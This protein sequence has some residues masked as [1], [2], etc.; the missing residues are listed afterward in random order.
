MSSDQSGEPPLLQEEADPGPETG[1]KDEALLGSEGGSGGMV[2]EAFISKLARFAKRPQARR[3]AHYAPLFVI[4]EIHWT[5]IEINRKQNALKS[6]LFKQTTK[7]S[8]HMHNEQP[9]HGTCVIH[10][11]VGKRPH[12]AAFPRF[13]CSRPLQAGGLTGLSLAGTA[14][15][16][17]R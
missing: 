7:R 1:G 13:N 3:I 4:F 8:S 14:A 2:S 5:D 10:P 6:T 9:V 11:R 15:P 16:S 17:G 12:M